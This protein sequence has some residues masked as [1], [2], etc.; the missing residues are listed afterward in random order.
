MRKSEENNKFRKKEN[1]KKQYGSKSERPKKHI[2]PPGE[3]DLAKKCGGCQY[4]G[5]DY[6]KQLNKKHREVKELLGSFGKVEPV[7]GMQEPFHYRNKVNA[8]FQRL[9]NGT[10]IS[11]AYQQGTHSV[12][13]IDE[14]QIEDKIADSIIYDIR[15]M[16]RSFK[17]KVYDEDSGYGLLRH[18]L[19]RRGF[20]T[21]EVMV[22]LVLASPILPSKNNFVKA[23]REK[24]PE[25][26]TVVVN[27]NDRRTSVVLGE[28]NITI[29]GK[30]FIED[31]LCGLRFR[32]SPSSFYQVNPV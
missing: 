27:V 24:H 4:Q 16:L 2:C 25:V 12:V 11:G 22:V 9:K 10:V 17:I 21:G 13:K 30:G 19:V 18:V 29:Y 20:R 31:E 7:I 28:R 32:I 14:C 8:T 26:T 15:G 5:M 3:C 6:E 1:T 23:L